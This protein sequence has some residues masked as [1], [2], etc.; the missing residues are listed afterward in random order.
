MPRPPIPDI[1]L[2][3]GFGCCCIS[4]VS[5]PS[6][7]QSLIS[8]PWPICS[9]R[10]T[11]LQSPGLP[12]LVSW[13][14]GFPMLLRSWSAEWGSCSSLLWNGF[15]ECTEPSIRGVYRCHLRLPPL[16]LETAK[17]AASGSWWH[18]WEQCEE[19]LCRFCRFVYKD[20][21]VYIYIYNY[22]IY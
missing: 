14:D 7:V 6:Q 8:R 3:G 16:P 21:Y 22:N 20:I 2:W 11:H 4:F 17:L 10:N 1:N 15:V 9:G 12:L 13:A 18:P 5:L 19:C